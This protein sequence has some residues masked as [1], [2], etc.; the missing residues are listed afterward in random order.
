MRIVEV[1]GARLALREW[2]PEDG[3]PIFFWHALGPAGSGATIGE[4]AAALAQ[5]RYRVA[6]VDGPGFGASELL[7]PERYEPGPLLALVDGILAELGWAH[8][9]FMGHSWGGALAVH[10][11]A[12]RPLDALVRLDSGH[13]DYG[14]LPDVDAQLPWEEWLATVRERKAEWPSREAFER[15]LREGT[16][17]WSD[18]LLECFLPGLHEEA[19][20]RVV[21][22]PP[23]ARAAAMRALAGS[24]VSESWPALAGTPTLLLLATAEPWGSQNRELIGRFGAAVPHA[25]VR[26]LAGATH[27]IPADLGPELGDEIADWLGAV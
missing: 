4:V 27:A 15:D 5:R 22:S 16:T 6:A 23:E 9:V 14:A 24:N 7:P 18:E 1:E 17:R 13:I 12:H 10:V 8:P 2:G 26:W 20:G 19:D 21:G 11:A 25:E 3:R